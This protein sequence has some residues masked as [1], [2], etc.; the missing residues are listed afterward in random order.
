MAQKESPDQM[1]KV[2]TGWLLF[3]KHALN[4]EKS[5]AL[6]VLNQDVKNFFWNDADLP[7]LGAGGFALIDENNEAI[8][9]LE[10][11]V[12][13]GFIN[14]PILSEIDPFLEKIRSEPRFKK[15]M[16][17]VKHEWENFEV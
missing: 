9:W 16:E 11:S 10:H 1:H 4:G 3:L 13:K 7:F 14:Y 2:F 12:N 8:R 17:R 15:L 5:R 6:E